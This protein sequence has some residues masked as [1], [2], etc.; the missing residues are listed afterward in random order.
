MVIMKMKKFLVLIFLSYLSFNLNSQ[1][2]LFPVNPGIQN[3]LS[4]NLGELRGDHFHM[5]LDIKTN[6]KIS[7]LL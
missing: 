6:G 5:G 4:G 2:Y 1:D 7:N 3:Y